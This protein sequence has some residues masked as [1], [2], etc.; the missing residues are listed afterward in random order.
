MRGITERKVFENNSPNCRAFD[1]ALERE[2][3]LSQISLLL[4]DI[5]HFKEFYDRNGRRVGD[6][7]LRA[8]AAA[9]RGA[10]HF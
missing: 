7:C 6:D 9:E 2:W 8:V 3:K 1:E 10:A 4:L 5:D